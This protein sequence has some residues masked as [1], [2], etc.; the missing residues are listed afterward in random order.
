M[1]RQN[2]KPRRGPV[3]RLSMGQRLKVGYAGGWL[4]EVLAEIEKPA[5]GTAAACQYGLLES[6][7]QELE[8]LWW[9]QSRRLERDMKP[10][11]TKERRDD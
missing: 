4:K 1:A 10:K 9:G 11:A 5:A 8:L 3:L 6:A 2:H 7:V